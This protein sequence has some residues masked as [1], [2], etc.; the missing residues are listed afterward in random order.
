MRIKRI[1]I[2]RLSLLMFLIFIVSIFVPLLGIPTRAEATEFT[3]S[4]LTA[5]AIDFINQ[6]YKSGEKLNAYTAYVLTLAG[7]DLS[8][9]D[10]IKD[11]RSL[12]TEIE[13]LADL[14]GDNRSPITYLLASQ[15]AD[16]SFGP[17]ANEYSTASTLQ[18]LAAVL[19]DIPV[20]EAVYQEIHEAINRA[21][22]F[23]CNSYQKNG[24]DATG[25][26]FDH[27][28]VEAL[29]A[30]RQDLATGDWQRG[31]K[32]LKAAVVE[33][34][35]AVAQNAQTVTDAVY[36]AKHLNA[37]YAVDPTNASVQTLAERLLSLQ[38]QDFPNK[39]LFNTDSLYS[40]IF[41]LSVLGKTGYISRV[42][43]DDA[44]AYINKFLY[45]HQDIFGQ[46]A[47]AGWG[48]FGSPES[49]TTAQVLGV[50]NSF[51]TV[52]A[53]VYK[54]EGLI[55]L[56][57]VQDPDTAA[58]SHM[59]DS[60]FA[61]AETLNTLKMLGKN[62]SDYGAPGGAWV[63]NS[64]TK[65]VAQY[66]LALS[67]W[68]DRPRVEKL[69]DILKNR[70]KASDPGRGSFENSIY[71]D[72]WAFIGLGEAGKLSIIDIV[73]ARD[74]ILSKQNMIQGADYG[75]WGE[76]FGADFYPDFMSTCQAIRAL[77]YFPNAINDSEI[78]AAVVRG[79]EWLKTQQHDDGSY[80]SGWDDPAVDVSELIVTLY[81]L[82][83][84]PAGTEWSKIVNG[85]IVN[86]VT[87]LLNKT[88]NEDGSFGGYKNVDG[89]TEVLYALLFLPDSMAGGP[90]EPPLRQE[91]QARI[92]VAV[93][94]KN[95]EL[96]FA[97]DYVLL[98]Q[99]DEWGIT[100]LGAL[101]ATGLS[102]HVSYAWGSPFVTSIAG[103]ANEGMSGWMYKVNEEPGGVSA[104]QARLKEGDRVIWWYSE[105][106]N[107]SGPTWAEL[108]KLTSG[109]LLQIKQ[110]N[111][112]P[113][114]LKPSVDAEKAL[115]N[116]AQLLELKNKEADE[117]GAVEGVSRAVVVVGSEKPLSWA[118]RLALARE[119]KDSTI[120]L[121]Q[122]V[123]ADKGAVLVDA[124]GR[125]ALDIPAGALNRDV[126]ISIKEVK[127]PSGK[128]QVP[129]GFQQV[130]AFYEFGPDG[131]TFASPVTL[132]LR[133]ALPPTVKPENLVLA[134]YDKT[135]SKWIAL[136]AVVDVSKGLILAKI[137]HF[138]DFA[139]LA[140]NEKKSF[141][142]V[143]TTSYS[144]A[145][146]AIE[147]LAGA[148]IVKG[149]D[150]KRFEPERAIT[151]AEVSALLVRALNLP[152]ATDS[153]TFKDVDGNEWYANYIAAAA[154]AGLFKGY[155]DNTFRP[156]KSITREELATILVRVLD[157]VSPSDEKL[158][159]NDADKVSSWA[160]KSVAAAIDA[161][162][163]KG[164][165]DGT[166][167]PQTCTK[168]AEC[169][170]MIY[171]AL[172]SY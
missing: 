100:A 39:G 50:L 143:A 57:N 89:A 44:L 93:V 7:E 118:D 19:G 14:L 22:I 75:S 88:L 121:V 34:A 156:D 108:L 140:K 61:T 115:N 144:W 65:T 96:L 103:Q 124:K 73:Y 127:R 92:G 104:D 62:W 38:T 36:L 148:G 161:G 28:C 45:E 105:S 167:Q 107:F 129:A 159:F 30:A 2:Q 132:T 4:D 157:L 166:F 98:R 110:K 70:Q 48:G 90:N 66:L 69:A 18:A 91:D 82:G 151:R 15:N 1:S 56:G 60:V 147:V 137:R 141:E 125:V 67:S 49:D 47:G 26:S 138:S 58:I 94:G 8:G 134:W 72:M 25:W 86:P 145:K 81:K 20:T 83:K 43:Q 74:Y 16:G 136:P 133:L 168:R 139:V 5:K 169:A 63:K 31:G 13:S 3:V 153:T 33:A 10:W 120:D 42:R 29:V 87:Y 135:K 117:L 126:E 21:V 106:L 131:T 99:D 76:T 170:V 113:A 171:R 142:D 52:S 71:S 128:P 101:A 32:T 12:K 119:L 112:I 23:L 6:K 11:G 53:A 80:Y 54:N 102:Y 95:N 172:S 162:L 149:I 85:E 154:Q 41:V 84:D 55:Y 40:E 155:E 79:L 146:D 59:W 97:P 51:T 123:T 109:D 165:P 150:G 130:S 160:K 24:Y 9:G 46:P 37:L 64:R 164:Y 158:P 116:L 152:V 35:H 77:T 78:Q 163:I 17:F 27:R 114:E 122:K 68:D 111:E